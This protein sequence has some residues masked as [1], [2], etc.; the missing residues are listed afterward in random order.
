MILCMD[1][2]N[3]IM[4]VWYDPWYYVWIWWMIW[5]LIW[6]MRDMMYVMMCTIWC[7]HNS[8]QIICLSHLLSTVPDILI[9]I[10]I[11]I[12]IEIITIIIIIIICITSTVTFYHSSTLNSA[13]IIT[14]INL[15]HLQSMVMIVRYIH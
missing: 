10:I 13:Y 9:I 15:T 14:T 11:K 1:M 2:M 6:C 12:N 8:N 7:D 3:D 4:Y 5:Y